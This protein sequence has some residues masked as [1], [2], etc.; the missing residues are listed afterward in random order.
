[1]AVLNPLKVILSALPDQT[2]VEVPNFPF[3]LTRGSHTVS[4]S[5]TLFIDRSDFRLIDDAD[6]F[7]LAP[8]KFV[9]LKYLFVIKCDSYE[10]DANGGYMLMY[11]F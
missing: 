1:M 3:D 10:L 11:Y 6:Y 9:G 2:S 7:G 5:Q 8:Q 4:V